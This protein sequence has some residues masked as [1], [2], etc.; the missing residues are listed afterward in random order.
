M[1]PLEH[2]VD[3]TRRYL[4]NTI[5]G[6][7][8]D[9]PRKYYLRHVRNWR[10]EGIAMP[11]V[12]G[13]SWHA[14]MDAIWINYHKVPRNTL[15]EIAALT[16]DQCWEEQGIS[17]DLGLEEIERYS[18]RTPMVAREM[19]AG[20]VKQREHILE[21][22]E[23]VAAEQPF[24]VPLPGMPNTW[25]AGRLDKAVNYTGRLIPLEHKSTTEYAK[26]SGFRSS[27]IT[28]WYLDSQ[29]MGYIYGAS[30]YYGAN[31]QEVWVDAA[32]V[33]KQVHDAFRF[34]PVGHGWDILE[35]W[36]EDTKEW[37]RR[38]QMDE[39]RYNAEGLAP[40]V[41]PKQ[42]NSCNGKYGP[43]TFVDICRT[44]P[45]P[46]KLSAPPSGY[47]EEKW[48]PFNILGLAKLLEKPDAKGV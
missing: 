16:F 36:V 2:S 14:A 8:K 40:G 18:P 23:L 19:L 45:D 9:C 17:L 43:C 35:S 44:T 37:V 3:T 28:S 6:T 22:A 32:L 42:Q 38:I 46:D 1:T 27:Y 26:A 24:A 7:Y 48:E 12:F 34:I 5:L 20:Y 33:H 41:F 39:V 15:M 30:L 29:I 47:I 11:L 10:G 4:D 21:N 31:V 13:L 25:Y